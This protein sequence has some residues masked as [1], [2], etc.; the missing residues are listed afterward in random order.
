MKKGRI[1]KVL[2]LLVVIILISIVVIVL[3]NKKNTQLESSENE[4]ATYVEL[5]LRTKQNVS[6]KIKAEKE[7]DG[8]IMQSADITYSNKLSTFSVVIV[9]KKDEEYKEK[10]IEIIF[11]DENNQ[12]IAQI[13]TQIPTITAKGIVTLNATIESDISQS[14]DYYITEIKK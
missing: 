9:N 7:F 3:V 10:D 4:N 1:K 14:Y 13:Q 8:L 2:I 5:G 6:E 11:V 12:I